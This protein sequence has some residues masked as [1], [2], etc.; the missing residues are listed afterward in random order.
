[1][2]NATAF[3]RTALAQAVRGFRPTIQQGEVNLSLNSRADGAPLLPHFDYDETAAIAF[4]V[5]PNI[6]GSSSGRRGGDVSVR[7]GAPAGEPRILCP[8]RASWFVDWGGLN[9][10]QDLSRLFH[11]FP[12]NPLCVPGRTD[13]EL[14]AAELVTRPSW[15]GAALFQLEST[16]S[17]LPRPAVPNRCTVGASQSAF[18]NLPESPT[19]GP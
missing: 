3:M 8:G 11:C 6:E 9:P 7:Q 15:Y 4:A 12:Y 13:L 5:C 1:M 14:K 18:D 17:D 19:V 2:P 16:E 10:I